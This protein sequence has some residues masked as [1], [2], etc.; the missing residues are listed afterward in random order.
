MKIISLNYHFN[1]ITNLFFKNIAISLQKVL[2]DLQVDERI[3]N[4]EHYFKV[5]V[6]HKIMDLIIKQFTHLDLDSKCV[7]IKCAYI[8]N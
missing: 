4:G 7:D 1:G 2:D 5:E 8:L 3:K 6:F